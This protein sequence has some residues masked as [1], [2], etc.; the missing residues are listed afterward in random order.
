MG[1]ILSKFDT[2]DKKSADNGA[3]S[4]SNIKFFVARK[5]DSDVITS[6]AAG[7]D[8]EIDEHLEDQRDANLSPASPKLIQEDDVLKLTKANW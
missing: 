3:T 2:K 8:E 1:I 4:S 6:K 7:E 5:N